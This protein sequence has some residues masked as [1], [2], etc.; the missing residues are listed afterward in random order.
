[1][2]T[3]SGTATYN[4]RTYGRKSSTK[5]KQTMD[6]G[7]E[8]RK[9]R[10]PSDEPQDGEGS[11]D[12]EEDTPSPSPLRTS[13]T[14]KRP[15]S[16]P[17][18]AKD[19]SDIFE[20]F[21]PKPSPQAT[22]TK[23]ARRMLGRSKT[24]S[25]I[26]SA[27]GTPAGRTSSMPNLL[28]SSPPK[29]P[30]SSV[31]ELRPPPVPVPTNTRTYAGKSRSFLVEIPASSLDP[32]AP[33]QHEDEFSTRESYA[34]LRSRWGVDNSED[35]PYPTNLS[36]TRSD[37]TST[38]NGTP[39]KSRRRKA[40]A[41]QEAEVRVQVALP[42]GMMNPLKSITEL[43]SKGESRRFLDEVGYLFEGMDASVGIGLRR[44]SALEITTKLCDADFARK[45]KA[46]DFLNRA[47]DVFWEAGAGRGEDKILDTILAFF[48]ALVSRDPGSFRD[49][50]QRAP[51]T[52]LTP[53][54]GCSTSKSHHRRSLLAPSSLVDTLFHLLSTPVDP[55]SLISTTSS[56]DKAKNEVELK[57]LGVGKK[58]RGLFQT[59]HDTI[60]SRS[61]LFPANTPISTSL[62]VLH[63]LQ[64]LPPSLIPPKHLPTLLTS[65]RQSVAPVVKPASTSS[66][67]SWPDAARVIAFG[68]VYYHLRLL[69]GYIL[70]QWGTAEAVDDD[71]DAVE[72]RRRICKEN[73]EELVRA[74]DEWLADGLVALAVCAEL[75][76]GVS[77]HNCKEITLRVLVS[78]THADEHWCRKVIDSE[79]ALGFILRTIHGSR[80]G[81]ED[82][83]VKKEAEKGLVSGNG[84]GKMK[85]EA[86]Q[87]S[88]D[89][90]APEN[91]G[92]SAHA[93]DLLCLALGLLTNLVQIVDGTKDLVRETRLDPACTLKKRA[94]IRQCTCA[95]S[96]SGSIGALDVLV[97]LYHR[98]LPRSSPAVNGKGRGSGRIKSESPPPATAL[99]QNPDPDPADA[100]F[101]RGH[102][103]VLF[104]LLIR[105]CPENQ[106]YILD[107]LGGARAVGRLVEHASEF[108][109]FYAALGGGSAAA[110]ADGKVARDVVAF[111]EGLRT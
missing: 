70:G 93:L 24:D 72:D 99:V 38:P 100:L 76:G 21:S 85:E 29:P 74:R 26:D 66:Y 42:N 68:N 78:L 75:N 44:A 69:D 107:A 4:A 31:Q 49:L 1:M 108:V 71:D 8:P 79:C 109:A 32:L 43:R 47:W 62:L 25:S 35:D 28:S 92:D 80:T 12:F 51:Y 52:D 19:L 81:L 111:L 23:L 63:A 61:S 58:E 3:N 45:A 103:A 15:P 95:S 102:L 14:P 16:T 97:Q 27:S 37:S 55:L 91:E 48:V 94:C 40:K 73:E 2:P 105:G 77:A 34:S 59:V 22:P 110:E 96:R 20:S 18:L 9:R 64:T 65:L 104:G 82:A 101:L 13:G 87:G 89:E 54:A 106:T 33:N 7:S 60:A 53:S 67:L 39:T 5:R 57:K 88:Y 36:P 46:A 56:Q 90:E 84:K 30:A 41:Q 17:R 86:G 98:H 10:K 50:A 83:A 11:T 6:R